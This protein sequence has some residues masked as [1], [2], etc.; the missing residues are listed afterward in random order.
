M[1]SDTEIRLVRTCTACPEQYDAMRGDDRVGYL[2]LRHGQFTVQ[3]RDPD[4][5]VVY[6]VSVGNELNGMFT[7]GQRELFLKI[8]TNALQAALDNPPVGATPIQGGYHVKDLPD[9]RCIDVMQQLYNWRLVLSTPEHRICEHGWCYFGHGR[10]I[11]GRERNMS[12]AF[13]SAMA[14]AQV[15][16][17]QGTPPGFDKEAF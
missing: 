17:G 4:G 2:R 15:W 14:A 12:T 9:G 8:A 3:L 1:M 10:D 5:P 6:E 7:D 13:L 11:D 16:D